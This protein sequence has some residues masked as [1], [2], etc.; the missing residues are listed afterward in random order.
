[1]ALRFREETLERN[2]RL[3]RKVAQI[4]PAGLWKEAANALGH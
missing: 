2:I 1:M 3:V 4:V